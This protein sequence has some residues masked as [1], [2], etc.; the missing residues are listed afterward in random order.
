MAGALITMTPAPTVVQRAGSGMIEIRRLT[1]QINK[2]VAND[3]E[4]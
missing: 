3:I 4:S 1:R 2:N